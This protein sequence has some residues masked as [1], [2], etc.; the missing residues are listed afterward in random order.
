M[1]MP[2]H[3]NK[4][5]SLQKEMDVHEIIQLNAEIKPY[6]LYLSRVQALELITG[7]GQILKSLGR[8]EIGVEVTKKLV[9]CFGK[10]SFVDQDNFAQALHELHEIFYTVRSRMDYSI[11]DDTIIQCMYSY[12]ENECGGALELLTGDAFEQYIQMQF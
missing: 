1:S 12:F 9:L 7:R 10:S 4:V 11:S 8:I 5:Q 3:F 6:G 2:V